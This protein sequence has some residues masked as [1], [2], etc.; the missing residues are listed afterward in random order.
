MDSSFSVSQ[1]AFGKHILVPRNFSLFKSRLP[2]FKKGKKSWERG[3]AKHV[4]CGTPPLGIPV[5]F[6]RNVQEHFT[7]NG[8]LS[9]SCKHSILMNFVVQ[10]GN[11]YKSNAC[12]TVWTS[13]DDVITSIRIS[14]MEKK[15]P[16]HMC[17]ISK[18]TEIEAQI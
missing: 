4:F 17:Q 5:V 11:F 14:I 12:I 2:K 16:K 3:Y 1:N 6:A 8:K 7:W 18:V 13:N 9:G 15:M 10:L